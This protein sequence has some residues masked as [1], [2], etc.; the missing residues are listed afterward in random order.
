MKFWLK[1][2]IFLLPIILLGVD[3]IDLFV[4][5]NY[6]IMGNLLGYSLAT[7]VLFFYIFFYGN[8][9]Y[10]TR[11]A[12]IGLCLINITNIIGFYMSDK[13]Y[14]FWYVVSIV[15]VILTLSLILEINKR[16]ER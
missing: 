6:V 5:Y 15:F 1:Q 14:N 11:L 13:F 16:I 4:D 10:F 2:Y 7:N 12:P 3:F 8:Y 9:C